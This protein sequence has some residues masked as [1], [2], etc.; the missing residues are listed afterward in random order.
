MFILSAVVPIAASFPGLGF[1]CYFN[2]LV[3]Y[4]KMNLTE[5]NSMYHVTPTLFLEEPEMFVYISYSFLVD[6]IAAVYYF[7]GAIAIYRSKK[8]V[9]GLTELSS[10]ISVVGSPTIIYTAIIKLWTIQL[11][12]TVLSYKHIFIAAFVYGVHF[13]NSVVYMICSI[14]K[15]THVVESISH[16]KSVPQN[17]FLWTI[18]TRFKPFLFNMYLACLALEMLVLSMSV[19]MAVGNQ[20]YVLVGDMV[21]GTVNL[22]VLLPIIW[23][24]LMETFLHK[25]LKHLYGFHIGIFIASIILIL[26]VIRYENIFIAANVRHAVSGNMAIIPILCTVFLIIRIVRIITSTPKTKY[27]KIPLDDQEELRSDNYQK[28][29]K[30]KRASRKVTFENLDSDEEDHFL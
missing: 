6:C 30:K 27:T 16:E 29:S 15:N 21:F 7:C 18:T 28:R 20:Y 10:W 22:F 5:R 25:Y 3:D 12:I 8:M 17:T 1:P 9:K 13:T 14:T 2:R 23:Y 26:P 24:I 19:F 11:Y 4:S